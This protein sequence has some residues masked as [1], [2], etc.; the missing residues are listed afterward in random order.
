MSMKNTRILMIVPVTKSS[1]LI[2]DAESGISYITSVLRTEGYNVKLIACYEGKEEEVNWLDNDYDVVGMTVYNSTAEYSKIICEIIKKRKNDVFI[3]AGGYTPTFYPEELLNYNEYLDAVVVGEGEK[4]FLELMNCVE[5]GSCF[6]DVK[7]IGLRNDNGVIKLNERES[8]IDVKK[9]PFQSRD[10]LSIDS[11]GA[12]MSTSRGCTGQCTFC[13]SKSFWRVGK[14]V[15]RGFD[16][17]RVI[18]EIKTMYDVYGTKWFYFCDSSFEDPDVDGSRMMDIVR[19]IIDMKIDINFSVF[20][21]PDVTKYLTD[22][23]VKLLRT[24]GLVSVFLGIEAGNVDDLR[25]YGRNQSNIEMGIKAINMFKRADIHVNIGFI[26][27][28]P[29]T[30]VERLVENNAYL[31]SIGEALPNNFFDKLKLYK[32]TSIYNTVKNDSLIFETGLP[33]FFAQ[34]NY[35][36]LDKRVEQI[37]EFHKEYLVTS[38]NYTMYKNLFFAL[39]KVSE[40][41]SYFSLKYFRENDALMHKL[42]SE[43]RKTFDCALATHNNMCFSWF[44]RLVNNASKGFSV[45]E[46]IDDSKYFLSKAAQEDIFC[47]LSQTKLS[48][49]IFRSAIKKW[50]PNK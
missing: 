38:D 36:L 10:L 23:Y 5:R 30:T 47:R 49:N 1:C 22:S 39:Q 50:M 35:K 28:N 48:K 24:A 19:K 17:D 25:L 29:Y 4:P 33:E 16:V 7:S 46:A 14:T 42:V 12:Y 40:T 43:E 41:L 21:R 34:Y 44:T 9:L 20:M 26:N 15:W 31:Y 32:G 37:V 13:T 18:N 11:T 3:V 45:E 27:I 6:S 2:P 8:L